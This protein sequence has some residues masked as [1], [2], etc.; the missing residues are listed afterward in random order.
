M[1]SRKFVRLVFEGGWSERDAY[2][3]P[4]RGYRSH[5]WAELEDGSR[6]RL[7]FFDVTRL[8]QELDDESKSGRPF[9]AEPGLVVLTQVTLANMEGAAQALAR[10]GFFDGTERP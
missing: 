5:V 7:T 3:T 10:E 9:L 2:E 4:L 1:T 8:S 6:H